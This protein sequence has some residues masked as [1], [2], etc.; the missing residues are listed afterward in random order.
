MGLFTTLAVIAFVVSGIQYFVAAGSSEMMETAKRN[1]T[2]A[3]LGILIG[4]SGFVIIKA[5]AAALSG[6]SFMF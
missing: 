6:G 4:L 3:L 5:I 2:Y 1:A